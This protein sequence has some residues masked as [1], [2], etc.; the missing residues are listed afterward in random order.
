MIEVS[1]I[2]AEKLKETILQ[3]NNPE[4]IM[5]RISFGGS[6]WGGPRLQL[7][8]DEL[9]NQNDTVIESQGITVVYNSNLEEQ[10]C[11]TVVDFANSWFEQGFVIRGGATSSCSV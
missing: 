3:Q 6:G 8:L 9:K 1:E 10:V 7:T 2:A 4:T 11:N 5:L